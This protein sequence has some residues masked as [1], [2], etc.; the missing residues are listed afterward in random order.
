M[1]W[2]RGHSDRAL[3]GVRGAWRLHEDTELAQVKLL[4]GDGDISTIHTTQRHPFWSLTPQTW[5]DAGRLSGGDQL[6]SGSGQLVAVVS[7]HEFTGVQCMYDST[8]DDWHTYYVA[9]GDEPVLV[10][11][12]DKLKRS[13]GPKPTYHVTSLVSTGAVMAPDHDELCNPTTQGSG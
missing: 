12:C 8:V 13:N 6:L 11:N 4:D 3:G 1:R 10:H 2:D 5:V 9:A 7:V